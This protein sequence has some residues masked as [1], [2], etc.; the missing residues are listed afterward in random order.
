LDKRNLLSDA[1][2][3]RA[4]VAA[5]TGNGKLLLISRIDPETGVRAR[6]HYLFREDLYVLGKGLL[7]ANGIDV[8]AKYYGKIKG[9]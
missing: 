8:P 1:D 4:K 3:I 9:N 5:E 7:P 6:N 2:F